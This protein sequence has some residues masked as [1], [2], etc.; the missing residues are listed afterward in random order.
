MKYININCG[1][2]KIWGGSILVDSTSPQ[3]YILDKN[4]FKKKF[5]LINY[6]TVYQYL[7]MPERTPAVFYI[8]FTC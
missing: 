8:Y 3:I 7:I 5:K 6:T 2:I 1:I 4:K